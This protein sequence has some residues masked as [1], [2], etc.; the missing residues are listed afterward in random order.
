M[1]ESNED[2]SKYPSHLSFFIS[3]SLLF[4]ISYSKGNLIS[5]LADDQDSHGPC[6][7]GFYIGCKRW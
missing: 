3:F 1:G 5:L 4:L 7:G 6:L 2:Q